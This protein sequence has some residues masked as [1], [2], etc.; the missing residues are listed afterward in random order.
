VR[1]NDGSPEQSKRVRSFAV[2]CVIG[3]AAYVLAWG[4]FRSYTASTVLFPIAIY[5]LLLKISGHDS[6]GANEVAFGYFAVFVAAACAGLLFAALCW[7]I[8]NWF[9]RRRFPKNVRAG[10]ILASFCFFLIVWLAF[11]L[12]ETL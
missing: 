8:E 3:A 10:R 7:P 6:T 9:V 2:R 1:M 5:D 4:G 11:P 12:K